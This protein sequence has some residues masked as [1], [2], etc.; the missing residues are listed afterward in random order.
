MWGWLGRQCFKDK[1]VGIG[2]IGRD[3][4]LRNL[5][6]RK[7]KFETMKRELDAVKQQQIH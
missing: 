4:N 2:D 3:T 5:R 7:K 1:K 6:G